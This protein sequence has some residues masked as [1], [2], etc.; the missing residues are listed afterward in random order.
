MR[1]QDDTQL[2]RLPV[3]QLLDD[4]PCAQPGAAVGYARVE[5]RVVQDYSR[6]LPQRACRLCGVRR[7]F[8]LEVRLEGWGQD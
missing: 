6:V 1:V 8:M 3:E 5:L 7:R 4:S 2:D